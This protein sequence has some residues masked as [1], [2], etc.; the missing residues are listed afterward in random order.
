MFLILGKFD[1]DPAIGRPANTSFSVVGSCDR[2]V[3]T[4]VQLVKNG[5]AVRTLS[6]VSD[7]TTVDIGEFNPS[8]SIRF[9]NILLQ[10]PSYHAQIRRTLCGR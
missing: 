10:N 2:D 6:D 9:L 4:K 1:A 5:K 7:L 8:M 3:N